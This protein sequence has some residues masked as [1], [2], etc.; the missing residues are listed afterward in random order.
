MVPSRE[1]DAS[2]C[3]LLPVS[4]QLDVKQKIL[5]FRLSLSM[6]SPQ[7]ERFIIADLEGIVNSYCSYP[8]SN[9]NSYYNYYYYCYYSI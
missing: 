2:L 7:L 3:R 1:R 6:G 4:P 9:L 8:Y 5:C